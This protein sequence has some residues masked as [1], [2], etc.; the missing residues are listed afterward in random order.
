MSA[1]GDVHRVF[2]VG[3]LTPL[4]R[5]GLVHI[6]IV[7]GIPEVFAVWGLGWVLPPRIYHIALEGLGDRLSFGMSA[8]FPTVFDSLFHGEAGYWVYSCI[9]ISFTMRIG[10]SRREYDNFAYWGESSIV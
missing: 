9:V 6:L 3:N 10:S 4:L 2:P 1:W 5:W 7:G 8:V